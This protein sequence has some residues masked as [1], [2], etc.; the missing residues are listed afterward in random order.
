MALLPLA[1][2]LQNMFPVDY[3]TERIMYIADG[4]MFLRNAG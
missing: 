2:N 4:R 1:L 3:V